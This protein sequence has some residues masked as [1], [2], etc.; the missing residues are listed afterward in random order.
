MSTK[1]NMSKSI[2]KFL[3]FQKDAIQQYKYCFNKVNEC[4]KLTQDLLHKLE[5]GDISSNEKNKIATQLKYCRKDRR[6]YKDKVE[7]LEPF[8]KLFDQAMCKS[9]INEISNSLGAIRKMEKYHECR[10]YHPRIIKEEL[11]S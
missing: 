2:E 4:D 7:E 11:L 9:S 8:V 3:W 1:L 5:L 10:T 6:Y